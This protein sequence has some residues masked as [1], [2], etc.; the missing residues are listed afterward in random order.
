MA[1]L[2]TGTRI[3]G[4]GTVD[5]QLF[6]SGNNSSTS[7]N[8]GALQV[9]GGVGIGGNLYA[10][11]NV[12]ASN[13][14]YAVNSFTG[15]YSDGIVLD[16]T[17]G[18]GRI[19][20][21]PNDGLSFYNGGLST[22]AMVNISATGTV[23][24]TTNTNAYD[25]SGGALRVS[26][27]ASV[28]N[29]LYV[30][31]TS[32]L[33]GV[34]STNIVASGTLGVTGTSI[35]AGVQSTNIVASGTLGVTGTSILSGTVT[36]DNATSATST[37]TGAL[38]V[39]NGGV[40]IGGALYVAST[41]Y[42]NS[43]RILVAGD[44]ETVTTTATFITNDPT[45]QV[46]LA[47]VAGTSTTY[48]TYNFGDVSSI[49]TFN[50]Y[51][52]GTNTGF[53]SIN[54]ASGAPGY[55]VY[56]GFTNVTTFTRLVLNV[57][58]TQSSGHT[59]QIDL[60]NFQTS[61]W[62]SF[63]TYSGSPGWT[64]FIL[65]TFDS[66]PYISS[67]K[68]YA[69][70]NHTSSGNTAHRT[71]IDYVV[72]EDSIQGGQGPR[73]ATGATGATGP[74]GLTTS[75]TSTFNF[76]NTTQSYSTQTGSVI[77]AGGAGMAGNFYVGG[78][79]QVQ[80]VFTVT[81]ATSATSTNT[82]ALQVVGGVGIGGSAYIGGSLTVGGTLVA[83]VTGVITTATNL[84]A[85]TAGQ[86]PYQTGVGQTSFY[87]PGT[88]GNVLVSNGAAAPSYNNTLT[89]TSTLSNTASVAGNALQVTGGVGIGGSLYVSGPA[90]FQNNVTFSGTSTYIYSTNTVYTDNLIN[91]H[92]PVGSTGTSHLWTVDDGKDIGHLFHYYKG[93]DKDAFL[94]LAN[95][96][97]YLEWYSNGNESGGVFTGTEYGLFKTGAIILVSNTATISTNTGALQVQGGVGIGGGIYVG[98][99]STFMG[100]VVHNNSTQATSTNSGALRI[101]NGGAGIGGNL[102]VGGLSNLQGVQSTNIV[103]SGT[104]GVTGTATFSGLA[105]HNNSTAA[106]STNSGA[107][108]VYGG[109]GIG[110]ALWVGTTSYINS[111]QI[112]TTAT[113]AQFGVSTITAGTDTKVSTSTGAVIIWDTS[114]L[115]SVTDRGAATTNAVSITNSTAAS[116][117]QTGALQVRGGV[118]VGGEI[119]SKGAV[120]ILDATAAGASQGALFVSGG[121]TIGI[122][123]SLAGDYNQ[124]G[125]F[126]TSGL[127]TFTNVTSATSTVSGALQVVGGVGVGNNIVVGG[128]GRFSGLYNEATTAT[129]VYIG[130]A[131]SLPATPRIGFF[132][133]TATQN[134]QIDNYNGTF[135]WFTPGVSRM[136]LS[137]SGILSINTNT[138]STSSTTGALTVVG[139]VG[140]RGDLYLGGDLYGS[141]GGGS[142]GSLV[143]QSATGTTAFLSIGLNNYVLTSNGSAPQWSPMSSVSAG[144]AT[145]ATNLA[146][147]YP[148]NLPYQSAPGVT[149]FIS[150][151]TTGTVLVA[152]YSGV[153]TWQNTLTLAG[154]TAATS[155][156]S[157]AL[158]VVGGVGIGGA[159]W[160]NSVV[161]IS[162]VSNT[163]NGSNFVARPTGT[164]SS[165]RTGYSF[166]STFANFVDTGPRR[167]ADI[168]GGFTTSTSNPNGTWGGEY[169]GFNV[170]NNGAAN[171]SNLITIEQVRIT[172]AST[173]LSV[174]TAATGT[175][176]GAL[177]VVGGVG[178]GGALYVGGTSN[179]QG[180]TATNIVASGTLGVTG[181]S[182]LAGLTTVTN[183]TNATS[184][185][186]GALQVVGGVGVGG[187]LYVGGTTSSFIGNVGIGTVAPT[188]KVDANLGSITAGSISTGGYNVTG[189]AAGSV[190]YTTY[191]MQ[192][193]NSTANASGYMRLARTASTTYLG[194]QIGSQSR[195][196]I[197]F[198]TGAVTPVESLRISAA[199]IVTILTATNAAS[200][201]TGALIV[202]GGAGIGRD[203]YVGGPVT[204]SAN[205]ATT[206]GT[207]VQGILYNNTLLSAYTSDALTTTT[208]I[209]LDTFSTST[210]RSAKYFCQAVAGTSV[211]VSELSV[212]H[213]GGTAFL[214][215]YG[216]AYNNS[217]L[218]TYDAIVTG[219]NVAITFTPNTTTSIVV[220]LSRLT[221]TL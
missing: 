179:L 74:Q 134:W 30:G 29:N 55:I 95:D 171:D 10:G 82:G 20:V 143:Y 81:N 188:W 124:V 1:K 214:N 175:N 164:T 7:T 57:N 84:A 73:G 21:G 37:V 40:G 153:P 129:G 62:D 77:F 211:H 26:G 25:T 163:L 56:V 187:N 161:S 48:G 23:T 93:Q 46:G 3:Y 101:L 83:T 90:T 66:V 180:V 141:L 105:L 196:G 220:K 44:L 151:G 15:S 107:L 4:T 216:I 221:I 194:M 155:T 195:D 31:G 88:A 27:G 152:N 9:I 96:S 213:S 202:T 198:L 97:G 127:S 137:A 204:A 162:T 193:N 33:Q 110:G 35:L 12:V 113:I 14:V 156:N 131:G 94:G 36:I 104:L 54:D 17:T 49:T 22:V 103:A 13:G 58:Y 167:T 144:L 145:T 166:Y 135:R 217:T 64:Q 209:T 99:D 174:V 71:W 168:I 126:R 18:L 133:S 199:G 87:G 75:T 11:G 208:A 61:G 2:L 91:I 128:Y 169:I 120:H 146:N 149:G 210:Y 158:Q 24:I 185:T 138:N 78:N 121:A 201:A 132:N 100:V 181:T 38:R 72:L 59:V 92:V 154:S 197:A 86:V 70:L 98:Q 122:G 160:A 157:G 47:A 125:N 150:S 42:I 80:G 142:T 207:T 165:Q 140:I 190:G 219:S 67:G 115:Q 186:T 139:G 182:I 173:L 32:N 205:S 119:W 53:Y 60:Y 215:E 212:F 5:S 117:T 192:L 183:T 136:E 89:L 203:L 111:S 106:T 189:D 76:F 109:V 206:T 41:S 19:S 39:I 6:V 123:L 16:Y 43:S 34:Q 218:G 45:S 200:T 65:T 108:Q 178:I 68:T 102:Y 130:I 79:E 147:G 69:R 172:T 52:T 176:S 112:L 85:G 184:T 177:Q 159:L 191:N 170:G 116:S 118:G 50:D 28:G 63:T 8:T 148:G 114:T 51:N